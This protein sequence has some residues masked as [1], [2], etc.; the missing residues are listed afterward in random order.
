MNPCPQSGV[1]LVNCC[2]TL[3]QCQLQEGRIEQ[4]NKHVAYQQAVCPPRQHS[5]YSGLIFGGIMLQSMFL[6]FV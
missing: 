1:F 4:K 5:T 2:T 3:L 6:D